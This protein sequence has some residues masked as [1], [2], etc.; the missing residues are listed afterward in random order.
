MCTRYV[1][2]EI[3]EVE[4][5]YRID[6]RNAGARISRLFTEEAPNYNVTPS[7]DVPVVRVIRDAGAGIRESVAMRWGLVP[8]WAKGAPPDYSTVNATIERLELA[9]AWRGPWK[10][11]QRCIMPCLGFY[12]NHE[13][14]N[15][16]KTPYY[17]HPAE[18]EKMFSFAAIW[19]ESMAPTGEIVVSCAVITMPANELM[20]EIHNKKKRMPAILENDDIDVW[21]NGSVEEALAVLKPFPSEKMRAH[22]VSAR[23]NSAKS[24]APNLIQPS[25][26]PRQD[27]MF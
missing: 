26:D 19:D 2:P 23:I 12:E 3:A 25:D 5:R 20:A 14:P 16:S 1:S 7:S 27:E 21:L 8:F 13:N 9:P 11:G 15:R 10:K 4:R 17:I 6:S 18:P 24:S 22:V